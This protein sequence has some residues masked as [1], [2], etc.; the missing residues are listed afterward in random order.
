MPDVE[1]LN[2]ITFLRQR[3]EAGAQE[4]VTI[5]MAVTI[6]AGK[7]PAPGADP[8][9]HFWKFRLLFSPQTPLYA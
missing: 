1:F 5:P 6:P 9:Q 2:Y 3:S 4:T 8:Q 7:A